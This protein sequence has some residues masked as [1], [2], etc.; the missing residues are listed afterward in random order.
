MIIAVDF[1]GTLHDGRY[2]VIGNPLPYAVATM[3]KIK[4]RG[5][6]III[7]TCRPV[8]LQNVMIKWLNDNKIPFDCINDNLSHINVKFENPRK[9]YA[10]VYIDNKN[11][12]GL[13]AWNLVYDLLDNTPAILSLHRYL[14]VIVG[15]NKKSIH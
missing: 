14:P 12:L 8:R 2:P 7:T 4:S 1:E 5:H 15:N 11:L 13:P 6:S 3:Q 10:D 9:T